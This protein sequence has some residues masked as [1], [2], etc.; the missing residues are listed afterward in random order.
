MK[1]LADILV[2]NGELFENH[3]CCVTWLPESQILS[4][5]CTD[6]SV[7]LADKIT[8]S[9]FQEFTLKFAICEI[10]TLF[11]SILGDPHGSI[12]KNP[13]CINK[14]VVSNSILWLK[15]SKWWDQRPFILQFCDLKGASFKHK[16]RDDE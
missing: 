6:F 11:N 12:V 5:K 9:Y 8:Q 15:I 1:F 13:H 14:R 10:D 3:C 16:K 7:H 4:T 2:I